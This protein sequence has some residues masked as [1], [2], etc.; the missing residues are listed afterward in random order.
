MAVCV[1]AGERGSEALYISYM[2]GCMYHTGCRHKAGIPLIGLVV[3]KLQR[4][5]RVHAHEVEQLASQH[6]TSVPL[7]ISVNV[8]AQLHGSTQ[9]SRAMM[10]HKKKACLPLAPP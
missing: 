10:Q 6:F 1:V 7:L 5:Q 2:A 9:K 4:P 3:A 8:M